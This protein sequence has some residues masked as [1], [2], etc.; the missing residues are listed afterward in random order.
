MNFGRALI[1]VVL[2][3]NKKIPQWRCKATQTSGRKGFM[4]ITIEA[5]YN[6]FEAIIDPFRHPTTGRR[7]KGKFDNPLSPI[8]HQSC[9]QYTNG[10]D[11]QVFP[12]YCLVFLLV[13]EPYFIH[14]TLF[15]RM[16]N[17][18]CQRPNLQEI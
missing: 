17:T 4:I 8:V 11:H 1:L 9:W 18:N 10:H 14:S 7:A 12:A 13:D 15:L 6:L 3:N 16:Q 5:L 2:F